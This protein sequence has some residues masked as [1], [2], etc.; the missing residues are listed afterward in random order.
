MKPVKMEHFGRPLHA[1]MNSALNSGVNYGKVESPRNICS[2]KNASQREKSLESNNL[3]FFKKK[4][5]L[6]EPQSDRTNIP[7]PQPQPILTTPTKP[8]T[9]HLKN[10]Q[11]ISS[12]L[13]PCFFSLPEPTICLSD[14]QVGKQLGKGKFG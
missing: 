7:Q 9:T 10:I 13:S 11:M 2:P 3:N 4:Q 5:S 6:Y 8:I 14:F 12:P 1:R